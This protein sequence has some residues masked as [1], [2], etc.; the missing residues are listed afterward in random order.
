MTY[1]AIMRYLTWNGRAR[2]T[3]A[4][5]IA[6]RLP[7][8]VCYWAFIRMSANTNGNPGERLCRDVL[9]QHADWNS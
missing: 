3:L 4:T 1:E 2:E 6:W 8:R 7:K 5:W 9:Q